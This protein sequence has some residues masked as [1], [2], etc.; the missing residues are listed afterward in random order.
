M[1]LNGD[2]PPEKKTTEIPLKFQKRFQQSQTVLGFAEI[3]FY[4]LI[5]LKEIEK[6][7]LHEL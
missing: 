2:F 1:R 4:F 5:A 7:Y 3:F 6:K